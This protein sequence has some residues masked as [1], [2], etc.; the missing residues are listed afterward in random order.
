MRNTKDRKAEYFGPFPDS[1]AAW[2]TMK[3][4]NQLYPLRK[5]RHLPKKA[6]LYYH[7]GQCLAPCE[8]AIDEKVYADMAN[9]IRKFLKGD[10]K[11]IL[12]QLK[13][14]MQ[15]ASEELAFEKAQEN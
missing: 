10:V 5:C 1:G 2:E 9:G 3:L 15:Q 13:A 14:D 8:Q 12:T 6:C 7:M 11:E 4:L